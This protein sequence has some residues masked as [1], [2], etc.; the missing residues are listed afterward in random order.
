MD[1]SIPCICPGDELR[2]PDGDTVVLKDTLD[3]LTATAI[4][5]CIA[6][7]DSDDEAARGA[8]VLARLTEGYLL[9][10]ISGWTVVDEKGKPLPVTHSAIRE[11]LLTRWDAA[12]TVSD[13]ADELYQGAILLPLLVKASSS[14]PPSPTN[15]STSPQTGSP[16]EP[17]APSWPSSTTTTPTDDTEMTS[18]S[19]AGASSSSQ[20]S[21]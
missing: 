18:L 19:L 14:S 1:V 17:P 9:F 10:G 5:K 21:R 13:E 8:E 7:R 12:T 4:R 2:H 11:R 6:F 15:G 20:N 16:S 3:F